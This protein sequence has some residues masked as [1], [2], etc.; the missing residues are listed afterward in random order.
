MATSDRAEHEKKC[1]CEVK[2]IL[3]A[4]PVCV[5]RLTCQIKLG[6][7]YSFSAPQRMFWQQ[8]LLLV[9]A[10]R[11]GAVGGHVS[12]RVFLNSGLGMRLRGVHVS[13]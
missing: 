4:V 5:N 2:E 11:G 12:L 13:Q 1:L 9:S 7:S 3:T 10:W 8:Y 6:S